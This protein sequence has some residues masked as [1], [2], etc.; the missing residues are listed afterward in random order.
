MSYFI[1]KFKDNN[2]LVGVVGENYYDNYDEKIVYSLVNWHETNNCSLWIVQDEDIAKAV[3]NRKGYYFSTEY[4]SPYN[5]FDG[6]LTV[7]RL[8][9]SLLTGTVG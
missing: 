2:D 5:R 6:Q 3:A 4:E 7:V 8:E 1:L 9:E